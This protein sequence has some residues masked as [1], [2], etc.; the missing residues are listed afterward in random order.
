M[1]R[2]TRPAGVGWWRLLLAAL[3]ALLVSLL[4]GGTASA[5][6]LPEVQTRVGVS[7]PVAVHVVGPHKR[8]VAGPSQAKSPAHTRSPAVRSVDAR[9]A[10]AEVPVEFTHD[11]LVAQS[12]DN[13][14]TLASPDSYS[15]ST[16]SPPSFSVSAR[17][18]PSVSSVSGG[19]AAYSGPRALPIGP[20]GQKIV[21]ARSKLPGSWGPG[22]PN[23]K[24]VGTR[25]FDPS[26][27]GNG[28]RIDQGFPGSPELSQQVD[29]V[30]VCSGGKVIGPDGKPIVGSLSDNPQAH[31]PLSDWMTWTSWNAR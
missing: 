15:V 6:T 21:D 26:D 5:A 2:V 12:Y 13:G 3:T 10:A 4:G 28:V 11:D 22:V 7:T 17:Q 8:V 27:S 9:V 29:H 31:I 1:A 24:G 25:W 16:R 19:V 14:L 23:K 18:H 20:W 30:V